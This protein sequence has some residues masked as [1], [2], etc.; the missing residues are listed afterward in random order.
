MMR[1]VRPFSW[2]SQESEGS[3]SP[4]EISLP[5]TTTGPA[6]SVGHVI[7]ILRPTAPVGPVADTAA[8]LE[9]QMEAFKKDR[10]Q[11]RFFWVLA[12]IALTNA[13]MLSY[14]PW[15]GALIFLLF[16][17]LLLIAASNYLEA[18]WVLKHLELWFER[19]SASQKGPT[20]TE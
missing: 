4:T 12:V 15:Y 11:E 1:D 3:Q 19:A 6:N 20:E 18:P 2:L 7:D 10:K 17:L 8:A 14:L 16:S 13:I 5:S 9:A